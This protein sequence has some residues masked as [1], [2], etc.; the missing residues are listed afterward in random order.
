MNVLVEQRSPFYNDIKNALEVVKAFI[1]AKGRI[2]YGGM[3][4]DYALKK[5]TGTGIYPDE[6]L[7]DFDFYSPTYLEDSCELADALVDLG[8]EDV[9]A[10]NAIH[11]STRRVM[12]NHLN[13][14]ADIGYIDQDTY[15]K[16]PYLE[17]EGLRFVHPTYQKQ[18]MMRA[19]SFPYDDPPNEV[20]RHRLSKDVKRFALLEEAYPI[21]IVGTKFKTVKRKF[22]KS[23]LQSQVL[24]GFA[25]Y[26]LL[27]QV[28][29]VVGT[30]TTRFNGELNTTLRAL[31]NCS[32]EGIIYL[33]FKESSETVEIEMPENEPLV[34][35]T[36]H[37]DE[38][39]E[40]IKTSTGELHKYRPLRDIVP[41]S[42][43]YK[44]KTK[45]GVTEI[46]LYDIKYKLM[47]IKTVGE[48]KMCV[49]TYVLLYFLTRYFSTDD[50]M[51]LAFYT[52]AKRMV[53]NVNKALKSDDNDYLEAIIKITPFF[54]SADVTGSKNINSSTIKWFDEILNPS[55]K[56]T[57]PGYY[58]TTD[59]TTRKCPK[60]VSSKFFKLD[61][62][63]VV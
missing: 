51:Y 4:I 29:K 58:P 7:P 30:N 20:I 46:C 36:N 39:L 14:V 27:S 8:F 63:E 41:K 11:T 38:V 57:P 55:T 24:N 6:Q 9:R 52:S 22:S 2:L 31:D 37:K 19:C 33:E 1:K 40:S 45:T 42:Y 18:D 10:I 25:A 16:I 60:P 49:F 43:V 28:Y 32:S 61:G 44:T 56:L 54:L 35:V 13:T 53:V 12:I 62:K 23:L 5:A 26:A 50:E 47:A 3:A 21:E 59:P 34:L 17:Y 48:Y 15:D